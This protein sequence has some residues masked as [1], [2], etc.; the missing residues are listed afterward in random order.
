LDSASVD[1][2]KEF[3]PFAGSTSVEILGGDTD[4]QSF[5]C[6]SSTKDQIF[7]SKLEMREN[8]NLRNIEKIIK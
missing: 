6:C 8:Q 2:T 1:S 4:E 3:I 5:K 7:N